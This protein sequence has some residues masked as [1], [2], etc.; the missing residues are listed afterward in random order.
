MQSDVEEINIEKAVELVN[1]DKSIFVWIGGPTDTP[2]AELL[3]IDDRKVVDA[4]PFDLLSNDTYPKQL[5]SYKKPIFVCH[6]GLA[7][8]EL[9]RELTKNNV[10]G[11]SL[12]GGIA[13][14]R[15]RA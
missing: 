13:A 5:L 6:H 14:I 11:Y 9:L 15:N 4:N 7:S 10:G 1:S 12:E 3:K 2:L 8:Y